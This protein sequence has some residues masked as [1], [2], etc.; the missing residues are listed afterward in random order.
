M[1]RRHFKIIGIA[2][3]SLLLVFWAIF[4]M[5]PPA[6]DLNFNKISDISLQYERDGE[7]IY[8]NTA[9][10]VKYIG[11]EKCQSC[12]P[13]VYDSFLK[14][15]MGRSM[16]KLDTTNII[17]RYLQKEAVYDSL[18]NF[19]YEM[20]RRGRRFYQREY[21]LD[22]Q[23]KLIHERLMEAEYIIGSGNN[24]QMYFHNENGMFY[25]LPLTWYVHKQAWDLSP[26][27]REFGNLRFKRFA[28]AKC[29]SCHNSFMQVLPTANDRYVKPF[30]LGISCERCHGPGE[31][32]VKQMS[33]EKIE[34][35]P[36]NALTIV[37]PRKLSPQRQIDVC[38]QCHLLGKAWALR[39]ENGWFD[40]RPGQLLESHRS[41][42]YPKKIRKEIFEVADAGQRLSMSRCYEESDGALTCITCHNPHYSIKTFTLEYYNEK[43]LSCH[44]PENLLENGLK[45]PHRVKD[46]CVSCHMNSTGVD[47]TLHGVS[48]TDHWIRI[49]D[50]DKTAIDW[51]TLRTPLAEQ[52][53]IRLAP[54]VGADDAG[55]ELRKGIA[56]LDYYKIH[57]RRKTY[58]D[59]ALFYLSLSLNRVQ[60]KT[61]AYFCLGKAHFER[62]DYTKA[63]EMFEQAIDFKPNY[64][65]AYFKLGKSYQ[66]IKKLEIAIN[67]FRQ[68]VKL[69]PDEP[70]Y[71]ESLGMTLAA[72][73]KSDEAASFLEQALLID[74][75][76]PY[77]YYTLGN[78]FAR[79]FRK[80][81]K[82]LF[83]YKELVVLDPDFPN[84]YLNLGNTYA[85]LGKYKDAIKSYEN[86]I[87]V[88]PESPLAFMNL[89]RLSQIL[90]KTSDARIAYQKALEIDPSLKK[91]KEYLREL[92]D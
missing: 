67:N 31:L 25:Q 34:N 46:D 26:G 2:I 80:P 33:G 30:P 81:Q 14:S 32:H 91:V 40:F 41:V 10:E 5:N 12:H 49:R 39:G 56:Y 36:K 21:R 24:L 43:C 92:Q 6:A 57:D 83:Y 75:Q 20:L 16:T 8:V 19:Y 15:E 85:L 79:E 71:L 77:T 90:G 54:D 45:Y 88:R 3:F 28:T 4:F 64:A 63:I 89:G 86:E 35:I 69:K 37:N 29:L 22:P 44:L 52:P 76:N 9:K 78:L 82:A 23:G 87:F 84:G 18:T 48:A 66:A 68:A 62:R 27:Y 70:I 1:S 60:D 47:N 73:G 55:T 65:E 74:K 72:I 13:S 58:L 50:E 53:L 51:S 61:G 7:V 17:E 59:S 38:R 11:S 42:Y